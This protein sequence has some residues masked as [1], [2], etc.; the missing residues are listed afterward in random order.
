[1]TFDVLM[2]VINAALEEEIHD[3]IDDRNALIESCNERIYDSLIF[4]TSTDDLVDIEVDDVATV[5]QLVASNEQQIR[6]KLLRDR[7]FDEL[8]EFDSSF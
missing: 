4:E 5:E 1:M 7:T 2:S 3:D 8:I 6:E